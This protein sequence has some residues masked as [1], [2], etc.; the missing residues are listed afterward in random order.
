MGVFAPPDVVEAALAAGA[1]VAGNDDLISRIQ[2]APHASAQ[3]SYPMTLFNFFHDERAASYSSLPHSFHPHQESG[4]SRLGFDKVLATPDMM[5]SLGK[6]ARILG[7]RGLM[8]NP[9]L[10]TIV[11]PTSLPEVR[12]SPPP[13]LVTAPLMALC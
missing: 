10:G 2:V 5:K 4:G 9:K 12:H 8:P 7:P 3:L 11:D 13:P 6:V 1:D